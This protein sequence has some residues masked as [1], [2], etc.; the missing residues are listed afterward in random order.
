MLS[1]V[2]PMDPMEPSQR[3][4]MSAN[5]FKAGESDKVEWMGQ[6]GAAD[7]GDAFKEVNVMGV[8]WC[9]AKVGERLERA[10]KKAQALGTTM[11][12]S[13]RQRGCGC[14]QDIKTRTVTIV[15]AKRASKIS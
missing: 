15:K 12:R 8:A 2:V 9:Q 6:H 13:S 11:H 1:G 3:S 4:Q 14:V 7:I 5:G 10:R